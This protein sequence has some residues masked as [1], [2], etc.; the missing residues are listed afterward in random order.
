MDN[1]STMNHEGWIKYLVGSFNEYKG[2]RDKRNNVR[3]NVKR[4]FVTA[5]NAGNR[6][7]VQEA[8]MITRQKWYN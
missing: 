4:A 8:L 1:V 3:K 5:Y 7:T 2:A 6:I